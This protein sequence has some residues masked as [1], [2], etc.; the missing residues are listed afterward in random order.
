MRGLGLRRPVPVGGDAFALRLLLHLRGVVVV[1]V[2]VVEV[3]R[4]EHE[5]VLDHGK[6][7]GRGDDGEWMAEHF[8]VRAERGGG[9]GASLGAAAF[10]GGVQRGARVALGELEETAPSRARGFARRLVHGVV[11]A[12]VVILVG[13][14]AP[15]ADE[16]AGS[17]ATEELEVGDQRL[18]RRRGDGVRVGDLHLCEV[19]AEPQEAAH[20][21][22]RVGVGGPVRLGAVHDGA[23][24][25]ALDRAV[26]LLLG[27]RGA[28]VD[29][30]AQVGVRVERRQ[31]GLGGVERGLGGLHAGDARERRG[32]EGPIVRVGHGRRRLSREGRAAGSRCVTASTPADDGFQSA[33]KKLVRAIRH[34]T[35]RCS[36]ILELPKSA[37]LLGSTR[38]GFGALARVAPQRAA[39]RVGRQLASSTNTPP[40]ARPPRVDTRRPSPL[41]IGR[42]VEKTRLSFLI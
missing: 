35:A 18:D 4:A 10:R 14:V 1:A 29:A 12:F 34:R 31:H 27:A 32:S 6:H 2:F 13:A 15:R 19:G 7:P 25:G 3:S 16:V 30:E 11:V 23:A 39:R 38:T 33:H 20:A 41:R 42:L 36:P 22:V 37:H 21:G 28:A 24:G 9:A 17:F 8:A 5:G 40:R 26:A